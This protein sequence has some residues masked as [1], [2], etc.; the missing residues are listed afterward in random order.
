MLNMVRLVL[1]ILYELG[2]NKSQLA[3]QE[4]SLGLYG[5]QCGV[6]GN[7]RPA[8]FMGPVALGANAQG[9]ATK[10]APEKSSTV[11]IFPW[12]SWLH[13]AQNV[14]IVGGLAV[15]LLQRYFPWQFERQLTSN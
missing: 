12:E 5:H 1:R 9:S 10:D 15:V 2:M 11:P 7:L 8:L 13:M 3:H 4:S 14:L 6:W